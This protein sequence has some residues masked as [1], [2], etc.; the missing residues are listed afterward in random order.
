M[1]SFYPSQIDFYHGC[2]EPVYCLEVSLPWGF[3]LLVSS[4]CFLTFIMTQFRLSKTIKDPA[5]S[6]QTSSHEIQRV[7]EQIGFEPTASAVQGR[8][9][10]S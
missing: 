10:P 1:G 7:V 4:A 3:F 6:R 9:S 2:F 5:G 8:R